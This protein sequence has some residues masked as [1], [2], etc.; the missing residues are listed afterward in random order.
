MVIIMIIIIPIIIRIRLL[1]MV[2]TKMTIMI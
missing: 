2:I 1:P